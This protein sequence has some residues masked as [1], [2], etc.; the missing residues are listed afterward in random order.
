MPRC[1]LPRSLSHVPERTTAKGE[2]PREWDASCKRARR[3][4]ASARLQLSSPVA[5]TCPRGGGTGWKPQPRQNGVREKWSPTASQGDRRSVCDGL[6]SCSQA[7]VTRALEASPHARPR[8]GS[9]SPSLPE[10]LGG[11][12]GPWLPGRAVPLHW[13]RQAPSLCGG[14]SPGLAMSP[15]IT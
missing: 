4:G 15:F 7:S 2:G 9:S 12:A 8:P 13:S 10:S 1:Q 14:G 6:S 11:C 3:L 5:C